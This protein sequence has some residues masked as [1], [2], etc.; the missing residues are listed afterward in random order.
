MAL[1]HAIVLPLVSQQGLE[2]M[3]ISNISGSVLRRQRKKYPNDVS[4]NETVLLRTI[5]M[6]V[7]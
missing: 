6:S 3:Y 5:Y 1:L 2:R 4:N 7:S